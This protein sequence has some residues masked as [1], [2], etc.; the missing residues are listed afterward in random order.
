MAALMSTLNTGMNPL[1]REW[2]QYANGGSMRT[3]ALASGAVVGTFD[4]VAGY[5]KGILMSTP[6]TPIFAIRDGASTVAQFASGAV[7]AQLFE[8]C[9]FEYKNALNIV[10]LTGTAETWYLLCSTSAKDIAV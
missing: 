6:N 9:W 1:Q 10:K 8:A 3:V 2:F 5:C 7:G 4:T